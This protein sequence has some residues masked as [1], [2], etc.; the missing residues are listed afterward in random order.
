MRFAKIFEL[1]IVIFFLQK[2]PVFAPA[3]ILLQSQRSEVQLQLVQTQC[4]LS[5]KYAN[6]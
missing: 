3:V 1:R 5:K 4:Y 2:I 6:P